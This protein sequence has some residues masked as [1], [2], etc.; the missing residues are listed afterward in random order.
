MISPYQLGAVQMA[1]TALRPAVVEFMRLAT[2]SERLDLSAEQVEI[3]P[4]GPFVGNTLREA[5]F[6]QAFASSS[7]R[8]SG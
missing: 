1:A 4:G 6:R 3:R 8:S 2:T 7:S 5:N